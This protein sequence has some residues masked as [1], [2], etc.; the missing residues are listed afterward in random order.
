M[1]LG[2][3]QSKEFIDNLMGDYDI[4][5]S[6]IWELN[7]FGKTLSSMVKDGIQNKIYRMPEDT[8]EKLGETLQKILNEGS[9]GLI[10][11]IL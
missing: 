7:I 10:C 11:I 9:G 5:P 6:K 3:E 1:T 2:Q 4:D 8:Q